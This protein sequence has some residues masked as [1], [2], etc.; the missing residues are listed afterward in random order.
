MTTSDIIVV[1][2]GKKL[3]ARVGKAKKGT[4]CTNSS[5]TRTAIDEF[6]LK[7]KTS[8]SI[9]DAVIAYTGRNK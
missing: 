1:R 3:N 5:L 4:S 2:L 8:A 9:I 6:L 7:H